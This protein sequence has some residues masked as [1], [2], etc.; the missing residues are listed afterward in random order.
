MIETNHCG[1]KALAE[2]VNGICKGEFS[3]DT[4]FANI[5]QARRRINYAMKAHN[6]DFCPVLCPRAQKEAN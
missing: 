3:I 5:Q 6:C 1:Q 4:N 2:G